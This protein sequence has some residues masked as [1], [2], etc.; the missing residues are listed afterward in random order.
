MEDF[1]QQKYGRISVENFER[2]SNAIPWR[3]SVLIFGWMP[4]G[5]FEQILKESTQEFLKNFWMNFW[6]SPSKMVRKIFL[7]IS[8]ES[9]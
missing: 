8:L 6:I 1:L 2:F 7:E 4:E 5:I 3:I 9:L